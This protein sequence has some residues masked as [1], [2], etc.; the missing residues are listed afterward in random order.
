[1]AAE[2][3]PPVR[4]Q[5]PPPG[6]VPGPAPG[7]AP[8]PEPAARTALSLPG[9]LHFIQHEWARFEAEK[10]R[11][12]A[13]RAEL[14]AQVAFLQGERQGQESLKLDLVR[15]IRMLEFAL[16]QERSKYHKLKFGTEAAPG[17][18]RP[19][20]PVSN[21]PVEL[22]GACKEGRQ[23]LRQYLEELGYSDAVL[24]MRS[25]RLRALLAGAPPGFRNFPREFRNSGN[26]G[27]SGVPGAPPSPQ[28]PPSPA[29]GRCCCGR[30]QEQIQSSG[31]PPQPP[32]PPQP[33]PQPRLGV[34]AAAPDPGA[35]PEERG[36][37]PRA[38]LSP[39]PPEDDSDE[40]EEPE[41]PSPTPR[42]RGKGVPKVPEEE[43]EDDEDEEDSE[44]AL[45]EFDF[46]GTPGD[47]LG[48]PG[49]SSESPRCHLRDG[50][51]GP[52]RPPRPPEGSLGVPPAEALALHGLGDLAE[53]TVTNDSDGGDVSSL[54]PRRSWSPRL[55]LRSHYDAVRALAFVPCHPALVT[56]SEDATLKLW[57]LQKPL[58]PR[59]SAA[60][61]V[62]PVYAFRG[63]RGPVLAVA[64]APGDAGGDTGDIGGT[65]LCCSAGV[66]AR[67][68]C[69]RLPGLDSDPY[70]GYDPRVLRGFLDGHSDAVWALAFDV[71]GRH[72]ASC[73]ADGT[74][75][76]WDPRGDGGGDTDGDGG[77]G[78]AT[79]AGTCL[80][81]LDGHKD[82]G[83]PTSVA[84]VPSQPAQLVAGFR[85]GA[86][87]L[88]D[89]EA[90]KATL[91]SPN[92]G[93]RAQV[94][95]VLAHP[96]QPLTI[97]AGD[98]GAIRY[99]DNRTG[100]VVHSMVAHLDA[101]TCLALDPSGAFL[102]SGSHDCSL[103]LW[104]LSEHTCVQELPAHRRKHHEAVLAV[105]FHPRRA[106]SA[107][108][109]AD[110]LAKV[111]V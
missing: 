51:L 48:T 70:D 19:E 34:A 4:A 10:G 18:K 49:D 50:D 21:G 73:S 7:P 22:Q 57:D 88:Y 13:E 14:Q 77:G 12:E 85:S 35:D 15:R 95:Q 66:D 54:S 62:E 96:W 37:E 3:A 65:G 97:M 98:D 76:L 82:H 59:K 9:I 6:P 16:K 74:V 25:R 17:E 24:A 109:G 45:G 42:R 104:H 28:S 53:L 110:A 79:R 60:L 87:V 40:E 29:R 72:L 26:F 107:S 83:V 69:W 20:E 84:F 99:L 11:W 80:S 58:V 68:R 75:R 71:T 106:L 43:E 105:A 67:I 111:F 56:A 41:S 90:T 32:E 103:R 1:M 36:Q 100:E 64:V 2:R 78:G 44:D 91:V 108:A 23:L 46:L 55:T 38:G 31:S 94:N 39:S 93:G 61:D 47:T 8:G 33:L 89:L 30:I 27:N 102:L 5:P 81:V 92:G 101:V 86:T 63:H 52:P